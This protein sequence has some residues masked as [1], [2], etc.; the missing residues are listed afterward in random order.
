KKTFFV[1]GGTTANNATESQQLLHMVSCYDHATGT[2]PRPTILLNKRTDDAHDNPVLSVDKDGHLWIF[3]PSHG[4]GRPSYIHRSLKPYSIESFEQVVVTNFSYP[5]P[6]YLPGSG[7]LFLQT[8]Y[9]APGAN[10]AARGL[11][12]TTSSD[13]RFWTAPTLLAAIEMG[14]YQISWP[15]GKRVGTAFDF[16]PAPMGLNGRANIYYVETADGGR[17]WETV[18]GV[19]LTLPLR[20]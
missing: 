12:F 10:G 13:G 4:T 17:T 15:N 7:F 8:R 11:H 19:K 5:Q 3:S 6:W 20:E 2:V 14:N 18:E 1:Y 16:H 9:N